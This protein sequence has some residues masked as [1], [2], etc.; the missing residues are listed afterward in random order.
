MKLLAVNMS[1]DPVSG[2]G[3]VERTM[4]LCRHFV[5]EGINC[6]ILT[7]DAGLSQDAITTMQRE[8][9]KIVALPCMNSR[10]YVPYPHLTAIKRLVADA[11]IV[12]LM[13]HWTLINMLVYLYARHMSKPYA[14][15]PAGA[16][17]IFGR[18]KL[19]KKLY[20][21]IAG[22]T[23]I[24]NASIHIAIAEN[25]IPQFAAYG[26]TAKQVSLIPNGVNPADYQFGDTQIFRNYI[27]LE[28]A[29]FILFVG[30]LNL[31]KGPDLL[32]RAFSAICDVLPEMH[33]VFAGPDGGM[34][35]ELKE[36]VS[37]SSLESRV[38][39]IGYVEGTN[40]VAAYK[41]ASLLAVPSR[42]EAMSIVALEAGICGTPVLMTDRCGFA[43]IAIV[44]GGIIVSPT[45]EGIRNG[46]S[47][48]LQDKDLLHNMGE[49][50]RSYVI[51]HYTWETAS[52]KYIKLFKQAIG[53]DC[54]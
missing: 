43:N 32:L 20:N 42:H 36:F 9:L 34:L 35:E 45:E 54:M 12:H 22:R 13:G 16:L 28:N 3:T 31:I 1:L 19:L 41:A 25:E 48:M 15:C 29:P 30:R 51:E 27:G 52:G 49:R 8:H 7:T 24:Q 39:F 5:L 10:F 40:K 46:L 26:V 23:I 18:S 21:K 6:T 47:S 17:P 44:G 53:E 33:L 11:D 4:Q 2:G 14:V 37:A 38:H 50:L